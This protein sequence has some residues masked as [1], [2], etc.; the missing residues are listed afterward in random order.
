[1]GGVTGT[2]VPT[3]E[4]FRALAR[5]H[6][7][8]PVWTTLLA[9]LTTPVAAFARL[10]G[11]DD[12]TSG[13]PR[14]GFLLESVDHGGRW[15][16]WSFVGR[17]PRA[18]L[19]SRHGRV[20]ATGDLPEGVPTDTGIL[21]ALDA[22]LAGHRSP[23]AT[24]LAEA[25]GRDVELP[26]LH[27]GVV[28]YLGY[29]VVRE[30]EH[31]P[32]PP[33]DDRG[34][35]DAVLSVIG[36]L[37]AYDHWSQQVTLVANAFLPEDPD[38]STIDAAWDDCVARLARMATDG[39]TPLDEPLV[40]PPGP[41]GPD[42]GGD[43]VAVTSTMSGGSY[44]QAVEAAREYVLAGDAF[45]VV[46]AQRFDLTTTAEPLDLYRTLRQ[47]NPSP[48][49][50]FLRE[51]D[52]TLV[53]CS[54]EPMVQVL[55]DRVVS[56]PIAG[57]RFRGRTDEH[58]RKLAA[59]LLEHPKERAEHIMLVDLARNDV[60]RVV[61]FGTCE[62]TEL[63][64]LERYSHVM[65]LTSQVEGTLATG[66]SPIDVLRATLPAGTVS[67]APKV[68]AMEIIDELEPTRR[69]PYAGVVGYLDFSGN[70]DTAIAIRT[71]VVDPPGPDGTRRA[72]VQAGA[73][74][75]A[76]SVAG[77]EE[78]ETRNKARALLAAV[79]AAERMSAQRRAAR[80]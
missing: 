21:A 77:D 27:S 73:G 65:H 35:P 30:V 68:R 78:L 15:S 3:A 44:E 59:E 61:E 32:D 48:Y 31:L 23:D 26:P 11:P 70:V 33:R 58:D 56:R 14:P 28:G 54:P 80:G 62:V 22:L 13:D 57:T 67:G 1:M 37:A 20:E 2:P 47:V 69:G 36:E 6:R 74:I 12:P 64:T 4:Q 18:R 75:V 49:M 79:P 55:G 72:S 45:Q 24:A 17:D 38:D 42:G 71:M 50:Y 34:W 46:L 41:T 10:C 76:D 19:V 39:A 7:V 60:G 43:A 52:L 63:M 5:A 9:D 25:L 16:R 29:D 53:G 40:V 66:R 51:E 8:V